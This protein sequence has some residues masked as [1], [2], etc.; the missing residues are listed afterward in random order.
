MNAVIVE[1]RG[2]RA[3]AL[4]ESGCV[5]IVVNHDYAIGQQIKLTHRASG[6]LVRRTICAVAAALAVCSGVAAYA[7]PYADVSLD[8]TS[9]LTYS[10]NIFHRVIGVRALDAASGALVAQVKDT[11]RGRSVEH[12]VGLTVQEMQR[13]SNTDA[14]VVLSVSGGQAAQLARTLQTSA[15][16]GS[17]AVEIQSIAADETLSKEAQK[18]GVSPGKL[19]LVRQLHDA[20]GTSSDFDADA[21]LGRSVHEITAAE[22]K[23]RRKAEK[24]SAQPGA[25]GS[26]DT[27]ASNAASASTDTGAAAPAPQTTSQNDRVQGAASSGTTDTVTPSEK[28]RKITRTP[29][30]DKTTSAK[31]TTASAASTDLPQADPSPTDRAAVGETAAPLDT[32]AQQPAD[33]TAVP[34]PPLLPRPHTGK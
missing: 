22:R 24:A 12:A 6:R 18:K 3:A 29:R 4:D 30:K 1:L 21:W 11:V 7:V 19:Y 27:A 31:N 14:V 23:A 25:N 16:T 2:R 10:V 34:F 8:G 15:Q 33:P 28:Q 17:S 32:E 9:S 13:E 5:R 20:I 26:A